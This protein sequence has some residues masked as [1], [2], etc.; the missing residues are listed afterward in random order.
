MHGVIEEANGA[1]S[2]GQLYII[3]VT[4]KGR[5]ITQNMK[6]I[7]STSLTSEKYL[8]EHIKKATA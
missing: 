8:H 1:D 5:I 6:Y 4:K 7:C 2:K 3:W